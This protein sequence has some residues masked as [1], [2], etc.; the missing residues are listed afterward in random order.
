VRAALPLLTAA[1]LA[2]GHMA[3]AQGT[4]VTFGTMQGDPDAPIEVSADQLSVTQADD[5]AIFTGNVVIGQNDMRLSAATVRV[6]YLED[7]SGIARLVATGGVTL[8]SG[9]EAAEADE[10]DYD[11][12]AGTIRMTGNVLL[13]QGG[14]AL[15]AER[16]TVNLDDGTAQ[17]DGRVRTVLQSEPR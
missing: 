17:M 7:R 13:T 5:T 16:M 4:A 3:G 9:E 12:Q 6:I 2:L 14:N 10:A 1:L 11:V 8:V 15:T